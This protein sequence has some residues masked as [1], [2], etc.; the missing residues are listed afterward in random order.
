MGLARR[1]RCSHQTTYEILLALTKRPLGK[2]KLCLH[3]NMPLD[4]CSDLL[5]ELESYGL[6]YK[7]KEDYKDLYGISEAGYVY[8]GLYE[9][10]LKLVPFLKHRR[11]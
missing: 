11:T 9:K 6:I 5:I 3:A 10:L 7:V 1:Y 2:T 4:R 8:V